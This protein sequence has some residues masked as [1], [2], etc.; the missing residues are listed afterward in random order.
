MFVARDGKNIKALVILRVEGPRNEKGPLG[1]KVGRIID[2]VS[3]EGAE[4]FALDAAV[5]YCRSNG[6][7]FV[8]Y[9]L[10]GNFHLESLKKVG[11]VNG[12]DSPYS[13]VPILFN[14]VSTK[15]THLN[16]AVKPITQSL[17]NSITLDHWYT[18]KGGGDQDRAW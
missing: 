1:I 7:D 12:D 6:I 15:R 11:F 3:D 16:F 2:F 18:T 4:E 5:E 17:N 9:F 13:S 8:D 10:S 14:P